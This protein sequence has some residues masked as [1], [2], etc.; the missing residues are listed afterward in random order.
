M[1]AYDPEKGKHTVPNK[2]VYGAVCSLGNIRCC[3]IPREL[4][5][6][7]VPLLGLGNYTNP[8]PDSLGDIKIAKT[9]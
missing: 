6:L 9:Q 5:A 2:G 3:I 8:I 1:G 4:R 7:Y